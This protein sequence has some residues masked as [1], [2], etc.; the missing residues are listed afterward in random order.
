M[1][2]YL[3]GK[4]VVT[5]EET[6]IEYHANEAEKNATKTMVKKDD[7]EIV[8]RFKYTGSP[9]PPQLAHLISV[10]SNPP[11]PSPGDSAHPEPNGPPRH[12]RSS[13]RRKPTFAWRET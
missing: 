8:P 9:D 6:S 10:E 12:Y 3:A 11:S 2:Y 13:R 7:F 5:S 1:R 4:T